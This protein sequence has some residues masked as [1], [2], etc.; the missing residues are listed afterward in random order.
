MLAPASL[1]VCAPN[2]DKIGQ[3][4]AIIE[5]EGDLIDGSP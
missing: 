2:A 5:S 1:R 3:T 4:A